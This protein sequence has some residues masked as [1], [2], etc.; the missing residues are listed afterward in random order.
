MRTKQLNKC[1]LAESQHF[2]VLGY[3]T[4]ISMEKVCFPS[5]H[6][7]EDRRVHPRLSWMRALHY[8]SHFKAYQ[9]QCTAMSWLSLPKS[10]LKK[11]PHFGL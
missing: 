4:L 11:P 6:L 8:C 2:K 1:T 3:S 9:N 5:I 10:P 7:P